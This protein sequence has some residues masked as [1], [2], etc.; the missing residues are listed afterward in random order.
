MSFATVYKKV[1]TV[2]RGVVSKVN[3]RRARMK[4]GF[5]PMEGM[6]PDDADV[7]LLILLNPLG[8]LKPV[9]DPWFLATKPV[10]QRDN[11]ANETVLT[12]IADTI[13]SPMGCT[14][15]VSQL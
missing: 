15:Q 7:L 12:Y 5:L 6:R 9:Y 10:Q 14:I 8:Y 11:A 2:T 4:T 1:L 3:A 13:A